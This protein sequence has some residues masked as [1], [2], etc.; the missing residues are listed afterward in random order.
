[1]AIPCRACGREYD[2]TLFQF[3]RTIHCACGARVG[4]EK[5][6]SVRATVAGP[7]FLVDAML[8]RLARWL[9]ILGFDTAYDP[10]IP[11]AELIRRGLEEGR[12]VISS[13]RALLEEWTVSGCLIVEADDVE[14]QLK[15]VLDHFGLKGKIR[16]LSRCPVCN[17]IL[18]PIP[19]DEVWERIPPRVRGLHDS[20]ARCPRCDRVYWEGSHVE[21]MRARLREILEG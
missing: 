2:V 1:M 3:G 13:D 8:G 12:H 5:R 14:A 19:V 18:E 17:T 10:V 11:D 9:R 21:R 6:S 15:E 20:F 7:R 16:L 4:L